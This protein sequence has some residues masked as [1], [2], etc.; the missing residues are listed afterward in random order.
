MSF[1]FNDED[2]DSEKMFHLQKET[3]RERGKE[4]RMSGHNYKY[5][6]DKLAYRIK[7]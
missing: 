1:C 4:R 7:T 5:N 3:S 6:A 2:G